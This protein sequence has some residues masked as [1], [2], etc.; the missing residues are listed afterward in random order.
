MEAII[1]QQLYWPGLRKA[2]HMEVT[3]CNMCQIG[4][5]SIKKYGK[6]PAKISKDTTCN[7]LCV[8]IIGLY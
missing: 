2:I 3:R 1:C 8:D 6:L 4:K 5:R 7:K